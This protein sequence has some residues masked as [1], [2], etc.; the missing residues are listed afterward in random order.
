MTD[1]PDSPAPPPTDKPSPPTG[2]PAWPW[3]P[4]L[5]GNGMPPL[6]A[7]IHTAFGRSGF[8]ERNLAAVVPFAGRVAAHLSPMIA[9]CLLAWSALTAGLFAVSAL[10]FAVFGPD[11]GEPLL[12]IAFGQ[13]P[14]TALA[15]V[16]GLMVRM[17]AALRRVRFACD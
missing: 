2:R 9:V 1:S 5:L 6:A 17:H 14:L 11:L 10:V 8:E 15:A 4:F 12:Q 7:A 3:L 13:S 16:V